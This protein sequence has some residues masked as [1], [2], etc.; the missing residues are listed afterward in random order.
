MRRIKTQTVLPETETAPMFFWA[1]LVSGQIV[2]R[3]IDG[4]EMLAEPLSD[5]SIDPAA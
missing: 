2:M 5:T 4:W 1:V 3:K